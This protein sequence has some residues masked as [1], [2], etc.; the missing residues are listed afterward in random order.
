[1][2]WRVIICETFM[3]ITKILLYT[4]PPILAFSPFLGKS[5]HLMFTPILL[6]SPILKFPYYLVPLCS[7]REYKRI[8]LYER[9]IEQ[10]SLI[11]ESPFC[12]I[13]FFYRKQ[14]KSISLINTFNISTY[15][16]FI[17]VF[18]SCYIMF[19]CILTNI[20]PQ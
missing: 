10:L 16:L 3:I 9:S 11:W 1:M 14:Y 2:V 6:S 8:L 5:G 15:L 7:W 18:L 13:N 17:H 4:M 19:L 12:L 20:L